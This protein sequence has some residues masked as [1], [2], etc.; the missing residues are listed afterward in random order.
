MLS[1]EINLYTV[2]HFLSL[3]PYSESSKKDI[4]R[5]LSHAVPA[6]FVITHTTV[7]GTLADQVPELRIRQPDSS[8]VVAQ[9]SHVAGLAQ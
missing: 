8:P 6:V 4:S 3:T 9:R 7:G 1:S 5:D 2:A